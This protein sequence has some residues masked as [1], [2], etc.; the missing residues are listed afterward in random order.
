MQGWTPPAGW[1]GRVRGWATELSEHPGLGKAQVF[2]AMV[3]WESEAAAAALGDS[4]KERF[5]HM[6]GDA[7]YH[8]VRM[9]T[10]K[11]VN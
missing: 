8:Q 5:A 2:L 10:L 7:L 4:L 3:G 9:T 1:K 6:Q 11:E